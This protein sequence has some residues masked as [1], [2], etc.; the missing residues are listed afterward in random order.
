MSKF[1]HV[2]RTR[3]CAGLKLQALTSNGKVRR[4]LAESEDKQIAINAKGH[5]RPR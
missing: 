5:V 4:N 3:L 1:H 2:R